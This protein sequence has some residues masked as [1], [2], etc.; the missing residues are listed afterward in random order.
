MIA[1]TS[2]FSKHSEWTYSNYSMYTYPKTNAV[3]WYCK[4]QKM[5]ESAVTALYE[6]IYYPKFKC[7]SHLQ[8]FESKV[9]WAM[10][11]TL[12]ITT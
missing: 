10:M 2:Y 9:K 11:N 4:V 8:F 6:C 5:N 12:V 7:T 1:A 3:A